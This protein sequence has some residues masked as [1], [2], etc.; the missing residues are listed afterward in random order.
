MEGLKAV[1]WTPGFY[2]PNALPKQQFLGTVTREVRM[3]PVNYSQNGLRQSA[4]TMPSTDRHD[5]NTTWNV[6][7]LE[8]ASVMGVDDPEE[9]SRHLLKIHGDVLAIPTPSRD[10][11]TGEYE[12]DGNGNVKIGIVYILQPNQAVRIAVP[13][14]EEDAAVTELAEGWVDNKRTESQVVGGAIDLNAP[15][16][17]PVVFRVSGSASKSVGTF[18]LE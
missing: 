8:I 13:Q 11:D 14:L 1:S 12:T 16:A 17:G 15:A 10:R 3:G 18:R 4:T 5:P 7:A 2:P 6:P 9:L